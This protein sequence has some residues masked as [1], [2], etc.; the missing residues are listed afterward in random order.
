MDSQLAGKAVLVTGASGG[1]GRALTE[2]FAAEGCRLALLA[3]DGV[4]ALERRVAG[5]P[6]RGNAIVLSADVREPDA[7]HAAFERASA[8]FGRLDVCIANAG[9]WLPPPLLLHEVPVERVR[10][11]LEINLLGALWTARAFFAALARSG[12]RADGHGAS[13]LF[14]G[15]TAGRFGEA[16]HAE[17]AASKAGLAGLLRSLKNEIVRLDPAGRVNM[18]E[19]GWTVTERTRPSLEAPGAVATAVATMPLRQLARPDD[20]ARAVVWLSSPAGA[21]HVSGETLAVAGG[22]EGR[23]LWPAA[24][25][26]EAAI[27][28]RADA[29]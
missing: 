3:H 17:Y 23:L 14:I 11:T 25:V 19:P 6:W 13:L 4:A 21:R 15:S 9:V 18:V 24:A 16:G 26:D 28:A 22:M 12:P 20:V 5:R 7:L 10:R 27:R 29:G 8:A 2:A 1:I